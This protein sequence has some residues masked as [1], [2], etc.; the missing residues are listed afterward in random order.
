VQAGRHKTAQAG[1]SAIG[2]NGDAANSVF[3]NSRSYLLWT[4]I[5]SR[6]IDK[7]ALSDSAAGTPAVRSGLQAD[8]SVPGESKNSVSVPWHWSMG[9]DQSP[10]IKRLFQTVP[11]EPPTVK[12]QSQSDAYESGET[13]KAPSVLGQWSIKKGQTM[14]QVFDDIFASYDPEVFRKF[15]RANPRIDNIALVQTGEILII[16]AIP[17]SRITCR[18]RPL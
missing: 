7:R 9:K 12:S 5:E 6:L 13:K 10:A 17:A 2:V 4:V 18:K 14:R 16:P 1:Q 15:V 11:E 3:L 8:A